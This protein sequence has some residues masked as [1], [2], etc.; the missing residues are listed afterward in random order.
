MFGFSDWMGEFD[1]TNSNFGHFP[2]GILRS[3]SDS[4]IVRE[5]DR[6]VFQSRFDLKNDEH[7]LR[8]NNQILGVQRTLRTRNAWDKKLAILRLEEADHG[9]NTTNLL[10]A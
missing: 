9:R 10:E 3:L 5:A 7:H 2:L 1:F 4:R 6:L 8:E